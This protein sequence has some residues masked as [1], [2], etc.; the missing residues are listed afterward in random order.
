[1]LCARNEEGV[2]TGTSVL[3]NVPYV[4]VASKTGTAQVGV[5]KKSQFLDYRFFSHM[6]IPN[7]H[8]P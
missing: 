4:Q 8:L 1:M 7:T 6:K 3:L 5:N 2:L